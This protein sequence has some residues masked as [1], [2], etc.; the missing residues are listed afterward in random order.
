MQLR[1]KV[2][3][4]LFR[5]V[6]MGITAALNKQ[7]ILEYFNLKVKKEPAQVYRTEKFV[8]LGNIRAS[9]K[10]LAV[11]FVTVAD[12][13]RKH[14]CTGRW[15]DQ[16]KL[17]RPEQA[18]YSPTIFPSSLISCTKTLFRVGTV[19]WHGAAQCRI[20]TLKRLQRQGADSSTFG[21]TLSGKKSEH[22]SLI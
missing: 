22:R 21:T 6:S 19:S 11:D 14:C 4:L 10:P 8:G 13:L 20:M 9:G 1:K 15:S 16:F 12:E 7:E 2:Y 18:V 3:T 17:H 5:S